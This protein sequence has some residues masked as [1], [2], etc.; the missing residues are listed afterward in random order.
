MGLSDVFASGV[1]AIFTALGDIPVSV[2]YKSLVATYNPAT[3]VTTFASASVST[4]AVL[5]EYGAV[6][7]R[8][9]ERLSDDQTI[10]GTDKKCMIKASALSAITPRTLDTITI[11]SVAWQVK[12][13]KIDP[14]GAMYTFQIR[15]P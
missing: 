4:Y 15:R 5:D 1:D 10:I 7:L 2:T 6:E 9:A 14:A 8:F 12:A 13:I 3:R 11:N